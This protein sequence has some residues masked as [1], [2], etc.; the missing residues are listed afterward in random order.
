MTT[1]IGLARLTVLKTFLPNV[2]PKR[3]S[4]RGWTRSRFDPST[5]KWTDF[6]PNH[7]G[8]TA[9]ACG[10]AGL[11]PEFMEAG[12]SLVDGVP[13]YTNRRGSDY[14]GWSA[15]QKFFSLN[16]TQAYHLFL[17]DAY[18]SGAKTTPMQVGRR[19]GKFIREHSTC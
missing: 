1:M 16:P 10:W 5:I 13:V 7:C 14:K 15:V 18:R 3:F 4:L 2:E 8:T 9:C 11:I 12:F 19:I 6:A 17:D